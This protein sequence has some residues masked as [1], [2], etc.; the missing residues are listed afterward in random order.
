MAEYMTKAKLKAMSSVEQQEAEPL[1]DPSLVTSSDESLAHQLEEAPEKAEELLADPESF[2]LETHVESSEIESER[3]AIL[4]AIETVTADP[5]AQL[6]ESQNI[7]EPISN[8]GPKE[9]AS[10]ATPVEKEASI[11]ARLV[12]EEQA[13]AVKQIVI[14]RK[15]PVESKPVVVSNHFHHLTYNVYSLTRLQTENVTAL[16]DRL[17]PDGIEFHRVIIP[18]PDVKPRKISR[19]LPA[20]VQA[21]MA[22]AAAAAERQVV[23][24]RANADLEEKLSAADIAAAMNYRL[25]GHQVSVAPEDIYFVG[26]DNQDGLKTLGTFEVEIK[27]QGSGSVKRSITVKAQT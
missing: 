26:I 6:E 24:K 13:P 3:A 10:L 27:L 15:A 21:S 14:E 5:S 9:D 16:L 8:S 11:D 12:P 23:I 17:V 20:S 25:A 1:A 19:S 7:L 2:N 18:V 4:S 22:A